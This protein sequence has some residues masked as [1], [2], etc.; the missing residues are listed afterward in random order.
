MSH[1]N[2]WV[3][4]QSGK[5]WRCHLV[6]FSLYPV[7]WKLNN[8]DHEQ[9]NI[10]LN[11]EQYNNIE[12][13]CYLTSTCS[14]AWYKSPEKL[15]V[16]VASVKQLMAVVG[17]F[18]KYCN[19]PSIQGSKLIKISQTKRLVVEI[20]SMMKAISGSDEILSKFAWFTSAWIFRWVKFC[21]NLAKTK[22][23]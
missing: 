6:H 9:N 2:I 23:I 1:W 7:T 17:W 14:S 13:S 4:P 19:Q 3:S 22:S 18:Q 8:S 16:Q 11:K 5:D 21:G 10:V 12:N 20:T 15:C